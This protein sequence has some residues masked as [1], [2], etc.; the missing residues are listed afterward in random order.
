METR[1]KQNPSAYASIESGIATEQA[2]GTYV[3]GDS[4]SV[5]SVWMTRSLRFLL[6]LLRLLLASFPEHETMRTTDHPRGVGGAGDPSVGGVGD[7]DSRGFGDPDSRGVGDPALGGVDPAVGGVGDPGSF[8]DPDAGVGN[9]SDVGGVDEL[10][11]IGESS[12][13][14]LAD[15]A[16]RAY[17]LTLKQHHN[18]M[19][20]GVVKVFATSFLALEFTGN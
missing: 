5:A 18:W 2:N 12:P 6:E 8:D 20:R 17:D 15:I 3:A 14:E 1:Y 10:V 19:V 13:Q 11:L 4:L 7:P 9:G 16:S